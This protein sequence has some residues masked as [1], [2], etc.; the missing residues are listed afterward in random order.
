MLQEDD[1]SRGEHHGLAA[2]ACHAQAGEGSGCI[3]PNNG[4]LGNG[5]VL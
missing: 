2:H 4:C 1:C 5:N 3:G